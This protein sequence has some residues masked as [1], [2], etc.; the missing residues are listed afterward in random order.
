MGPAKSPL[1]NEDF[2]K[3]L[4]FVLEHETE[5]KPKHWGDYREEFVATEHDADDP[6]GTTRYGVDARSHPGVCIETLTLE[7]ATEIYRQEWLKAHCDSIAFPLNAVYFDG[8]VN[9]G[10]G[11][12][13]KFLQRAVGTHDDGAFGPATKAAVLA[14]VERLGAEEIALK[15]CK[16]KADFYEKLAKKN[17][18]SEKYL[19]GWLNRVLDMVKAHLNVAADDAW[20]VRVSDIAKGGEHGVA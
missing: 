14:A 2:D 9:A 10:N 12:A 1:M 8:C 19:G 13:T 6:G 7:Q 11:Q 3:A 20:L 18:K 17:S 15:I 4:K 5:F 16:M